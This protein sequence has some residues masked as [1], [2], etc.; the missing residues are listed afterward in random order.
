VISDPLELTNRA[1]A[2]SD[3]VRRLSKEL[4]AWWPGR[5]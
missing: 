3:V 5:E 4:D 2:H 1:A